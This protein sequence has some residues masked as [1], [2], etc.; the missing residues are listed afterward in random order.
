[1]ESNAQ[2]AE[3]DYWENRFE[4]VRK[5]YS[6]NISFSVFFFLQS[7]FFIGIHIFIVF[8]ALLLIYSTFN[9]ALLCRKHTTNGWPVS[10]PI[11]KFFSS[12]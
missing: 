5:I 2:Y 1:M 3:K 12:I 9:Y 11:G 4:K 6:Q 10:I 8:L 7:F